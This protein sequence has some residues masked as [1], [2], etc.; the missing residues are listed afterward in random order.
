MAISFILDFIKSKLILK[1]VNLSDSLS[2]LRN[3]E[4]LSTP[5]EITRKIHNQLDDLTQSDYSIN[6][7]GFLV[8]T[9]SQKMKELTKK[10]F[11]I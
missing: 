1:A 2:T 4:N 9:K 6:L 7:F 11:K 8:S 5:N 10:L 3:I